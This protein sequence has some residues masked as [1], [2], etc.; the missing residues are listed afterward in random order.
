MLWKVPQSIYSSYSD[1]HVI[2][3]SGVILIIIL[4]VGIILQ[5][6]LLLQIVFG[7]YMVLLHG[8]ALILEKV[9][10]D[11]LEMNDYNWMLQL[12]SSTFEMVA[13]CPLKKLIGLRVHLHFN[14]FWCLY[15]WLLFLENWLLRLLLLL[16]LHLLLRHLF[17]DLVLTYAGFI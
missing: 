11:S 7:H 1:P 10:Q 14:T 16:L 13:V 8:N 5:V 2:R 6:G 9:A 4:L 12:I 15:L 17:S 3:W